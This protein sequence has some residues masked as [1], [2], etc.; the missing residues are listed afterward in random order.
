MKRDGGA[1]QIDT[2]IP[3]GKA[4]LRAGFCCFSASDVNFRGALGSFCKDSDAVAQHFSEALYDGESSAGVCASATIGQLTDAELGHQWG[5]TGQNTEGTFRAGQYGFNHALAQEL[6][7]RRD[8]NQLD[9]V[10]KHLRF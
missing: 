8:D 7:F 6:L 5:V 2:R 10:R 3:G 1:V 4:L 9:G